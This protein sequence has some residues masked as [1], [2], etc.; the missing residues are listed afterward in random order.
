MKTEDFYVSEFRAVSKIHDARGRY[1]DMK[2]R[3]CAVVVF[4]EKGSIRFSQN[5]KIFISDGKYP[6]FIPAG[7]SYINECIEEADSLM[8]SFNTIGSY[9]S[10]CYLS[11][12]TAAECSWYFELIEKAQISNKEGYRQKQLSLFYDMLEKMFSH[13]KRKESISERC[14]GM[15]RERYNNKYLVCSDISRELFVSEGYL[16]REFKKEYNISVGEYLR[17]IRMENAR[18]LL[19]ERRGVGEV[20]SA[21]GYSDVYQFSR[22]YKKHFGYSPSHTADAGGLHEMVQI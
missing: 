21:V 17:K 16:R 19:L 2:N 13:A 3:H 10:I 18:E 6:I 12:M 15:I 9:T 7:A 5:K 11:P 4:T 1:L 20:A 8:F 14:A 22:A